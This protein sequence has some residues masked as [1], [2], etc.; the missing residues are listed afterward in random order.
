MNVKVV[1]ISFSLVAILTVFGLVVVNRASEKIVGAVIP[2]G[3][4]AVT[5]I[6]FSLFIF[7]AEPPIEEV[8]ASTFTYDA[9]TKM[10]SNLP[11]LWNRRFEDARFAPAELFKQ[12]PELF[13][14]PKDK[15]GD[16]LYHD[17]LQRSLV[18]WIGMIYRG[19][20]QT[21]ILS[22]ESAIGR[23]LRFQPA[24]AT[25]PA[26]SKILTTAEIAKLLEGNKFASINTGIP[27]QI[28]LPPGATLTISPPQRDASNLETSEIRIRDWFCTIS[29]RTM[30]SGGIRSIGSYRKM[31]GISDEESGKLWTARYI[32]RFKA[33]FSRWLSG[34][35]EMPKYKK[36]A[37]QLADG[38]KAQFDEETIWRRTRDDYL[39]L[40]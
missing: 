5:G 35:P 28:A 38:L 14:D 19:S 12:R 6:L 40:K 8:F 26:P 18:D 34:N 17:L 30:R 13:N 36:W 39:F 3:V 20:W 2:I 1:L 10:P 27:P 24:E 23:E 21:E 11:W 25:A 37:R 15:G 7:G 33:E 16:S 22:F 29:I 9:D 31:D 4:A 32:V